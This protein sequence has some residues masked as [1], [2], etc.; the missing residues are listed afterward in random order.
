MA[1]FQSFKPATRYQAPKLVAATMSQGILDAQAKATENAQ[2][3][4]TYAGVGNMV[5]AYDKWGDANDFS[6]ISDY[7]RDKGIMSEKTPP[8]LNPGS[9]WNDP[10]AML[11]STDAALVTDNTASLPPEASNMLGGF[12]DPSGLAD[13]LRGSGD[14]TDAAGTVTDVADAASA[15][16][17]AL[18][19]GGA[20][21]AGLGDL[22][23]GNI[24]AAVGK[25]ALIRMAS[26]GGP[27]AVLAAQL[28]SAFV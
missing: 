15:G 17:D 14:M 28:L 11:E 8:S 23:Q 3:A 6:P 4:A 20:G 22:A 5:G 18:S 19:I 2:R 21:T 26:L 16:S 10:N 27:G 25:Q 7:L 24:G 12:E 1:M 9:S 13:A